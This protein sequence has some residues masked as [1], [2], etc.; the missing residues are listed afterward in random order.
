MCGVYGHR[1]RY[2][3]VEGTSVYVRMEGE[4]NLCRC[5]VWIWSIE[6]YAGIWICALGK[7]CGVC[8]GWWEN[9]HIC[10]GSV[11]VGMCVCMFVEVR[12]SWTHADGCGPCGHVDM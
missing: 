11:D 5:G 10:E 2:S 8:M 7:I 12:N 6:R 3:D 1:C 4:K 9:V